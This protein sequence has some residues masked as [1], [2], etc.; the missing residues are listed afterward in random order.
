VGHLMRRWRSGQK[1][2]AQLHI[3]LIAF[4]CLFD[5]ARRHEEHGQSS[6]GRAGSPSLTSQVTT[7]TTDT[8]SLGIPTQLDPVDAPRDADAD[9]DVIALVRRGDVTAA[10]VRLMDRHGAGIYRYCCEEL[11]DAALA[12]DTHQQ[13]FIA[14]F[15]CLPS[16]EGRSSVRTWLFGIAHHRV[17][18]AVKARN[19]GR[20]RIE[21]LGDYEPTVPFD[22]RPAPDEALDDMRLC[23]A[24]RAEISLLSEDVRAAI[25]LRYQHGLSIVEVAKVLDEKPG[26]IS[27][28]LLRAMPLLRDRIEA[29]MNRRPRHR[30]AAPR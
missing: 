14:A 19:R 18:D 16:F 8:L 24:L 11:H 5:K 30:V 4:L 29:R 23:S 13:I 25:L 20:A 2:L 10:L 28:R 1:F 3:E 6:S 9:R 12:D 7:M 26:T 21:K 17:L 22:Q 15:R 27:A